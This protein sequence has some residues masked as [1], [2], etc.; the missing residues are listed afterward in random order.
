MEHN[1][2]IRVDISSWRYNYT[3]DGI[4]GK[5]KDV[6]CTTFCK[7]VVDHTK[8]RLDTLV[9]LISEQAGDDIDKLEDYINKLKRIW[10]LIENESPLSVQNE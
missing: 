7:S 8:V 10:K 2:I 4:I 9:Y 5:V 3:S 6:Y 1:A